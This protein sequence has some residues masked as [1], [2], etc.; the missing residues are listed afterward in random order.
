[1]RL[2]LADASATRELGRSL[3][4]VLAPGD[5]VILVGDLGAGK[6]TL[7]QGIGAGLGVE[8]TVAS[9]TFIIARAHRPA[10][11]R[12]ALIHVDAYRLGSLAELDDLDLDESIDDAVT[13]VEWGAG[14]AEV[15]A[16]SHLVITLE[17]ERGGAM[18]DPEAG[19]RT[20]TLEGH[21]PRWEGVAL[22]RIASP[23]P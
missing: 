17:R 15:L 16:E 19:V 2:T 13:V 5:L 1:M 6:T 8:G 23:L 7:A 4:E 14:I 9:P 22:G 20:A 18:G 10:P 21:G 12:P 11:G 3:T